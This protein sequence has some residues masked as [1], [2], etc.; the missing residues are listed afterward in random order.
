[1]QSV[2]TLRFQ[3]FTATVLSLFILS[4]TIAHAQI[5]PGWKEYFPTKRIHLDDEAGLQTFTWTSY[6]SVCTPICADYRYDA[7]TN[8]ETFRILNTKSNRSEI[9]LQNEY[10]S[11][12]RQFE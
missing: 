10:S 3:K 6:K 12:S 11:G 2:F 9:R 5:G 4:L 1:M 7:S 8:S